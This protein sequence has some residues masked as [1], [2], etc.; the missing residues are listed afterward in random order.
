MDERDN[1][2]SVVTTP[3]GFF[4]LSLLIVEGFLG[5]IVIGS[6]AALSSDAKVTGMWMAIGAF[7]GIT[8]I[9]ALMVWLIPTN[10]TLRGQDWAD[11]AK[12]KNN[13]A[14]SD[15]PKT[16]VEIEKLEATTSKKS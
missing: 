9:V 6:G 5:I 2:I 7:A 12:L 13:W 11:Q 16:K 14:T 8:L 4:A 3:L 1:I 15:A 10:L